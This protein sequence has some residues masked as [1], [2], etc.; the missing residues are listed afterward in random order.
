MNIK[1]QFQYNP[2]I[3]ISAA[4]IGISKWKWISIDDSN[5]EQAREVMKQ[6][7]FDVLPIKDSNGEITAYFSTQEWN[8]YDYLNKISISNAETIYY[9]LSFKDLIRKFSTEDTNFYFLTDYNQTLGLVSYVNLN[10]QLVYN[11]L[12]YV[13]ADIE[14]SVAAILKEYIDEKTI[15]EVFETSDNSHLNKIAKMH[16]ENINNNQDNSI[17]HYMYLQTI[18]ILIKKFLP[19]LP[20]EY[21]KLG[22]Y[23]QKFGTDSV[24][25]T[26]RNK[27]MHPVQ[28]ILSDKKSINQI[29]ELLTDYEAIKEI[30]GYRENL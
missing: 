19:K 16:Q 5:V 2:E 7:R 3:E 4:Q 1:K 12:F 18:G 8:N 6:N 23:S 24:Y 27:V 9:R 13:L 15:L 25:T 17:F 28:P 20:N 11:Y 22:K 26:I 14:R 10:C 30:V 21:K 29:D